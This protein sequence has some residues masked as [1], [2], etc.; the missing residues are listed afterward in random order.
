MAEWYDLTQ[1]LKNGGMK[2]VNRKFVYTWSQPSALVTKK[3]PH[4]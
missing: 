1:K 4:R 2:E 3:K